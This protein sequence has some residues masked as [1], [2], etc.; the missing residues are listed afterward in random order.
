MKLVLEGKNHQN[1]D[2][3]NRSPRTRWLLI[4]T[5]LK[6][7]SKKSRGDRLY[8]EFITKCFLPTKMTDK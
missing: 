4:N 1:L 7:D 5:G 2:D 6:C 3:S 8:R